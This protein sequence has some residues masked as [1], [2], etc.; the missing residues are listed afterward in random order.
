MFNKKK[1]RDRERAMKMVQVPLPVLIRQVIYDSLLEPAESIA[2][3]LG[4]PPISEEV[5]EMEERASQ[6]RIEVFSHI[7]PFID[8]H[9]DI[10]SKIAAAAYMFTDEEDLDKLEGIDMD[11]MTKLFRLVSL[12]ATISCISTL[13]NLGLVKVTGGKHGK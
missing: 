10:A 9:A 7:L 2:E 8:S 5:S 4:L 11:E 1:R 13:T 6:D 3:A 12:S